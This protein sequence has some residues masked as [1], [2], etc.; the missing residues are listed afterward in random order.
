VKRLTAPL[1]GP[2]IRLGSVTG[3]EHS[4]VWLSDRPLN[5]GQGARG[6]AL[7]CLDI[8]EEEVTSYEW[9]EDEKPFR[10]FLCPAKLV[11]RYGPPRVVEA[12]YPSSR[13]DFMR[14]LMTLECLGTDAAQ[15]KAARMREVLPFLELHGLVQEEAS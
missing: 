9:H 15:A 13:R 5:D 3:T 4:G 2:F 7:L 6:D 11:N 1:Q 14:L 10:E 8:P 12:D